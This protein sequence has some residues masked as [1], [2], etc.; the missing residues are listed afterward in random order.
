MLYER[1]KIRE[2]NIK[3]TEIIDGIRTKYSLCPHCAGEMDFGQCAAIL[4]GEFSLGK[5]LSG[6]LG[7]EDDEEETDARGKVVCPTCG[8]SSNDSVE[9]SRLGYPDYYGVFDLFVSDKMK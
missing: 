4:D 5:L 8:T 3:Y 7:L 6:P 1:Y 9:N 2:T